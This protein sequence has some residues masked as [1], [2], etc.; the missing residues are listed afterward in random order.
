MKRSI[1]V[2]FLPQ[3][4]VEPI[5]DKPRILIIDDNRDFTLSAKRALERTGRS[6]VCE[7]N[8]A[9]KLISQTRPCRE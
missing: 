9:T 7:E 2:N 3:D 6:F 8:D 5:Q 4:V 1:E